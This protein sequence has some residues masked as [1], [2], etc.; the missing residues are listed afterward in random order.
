M[1][2]TCDDVD[3]IL[4]HFE[5]QIKVRKLESLNNMY[6]T[7][8]SGRKVWTYLN[9]VIQSLKDEIKKQ[10][11]LQ[12]IKDHFSNV[13]IEKDGM[14]LDIQFVLKNNIWR[15]DVDN[16][17]KYTIDS[18]AEASGLDDRRMIKQHSEKIINDISGDDYE[19]IIFNCYI[20]KDCEVN[21]KKYSH[22]LQKDVL[23]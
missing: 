18:F 7:G 16:M 10:L 17:L 8:S 23:V 12:S 13:D 2:K 11:N 3:N 21:I 19:Y 14:A 5:Y 6:L 20:I 1:N 9:P 15:R 4:H 22:I